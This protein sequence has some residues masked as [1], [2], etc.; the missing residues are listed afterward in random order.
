MAGSYP[1]R[2]LIHR[3]TIQRTTGSNIDTRGLDS[4]IWT[5]ATTNIPCRLVFLSETENRDGRNT[6]IE[7]WTGYFTGTVD[8]KASDRLYWNSE[9]KYFEITSLRKSHNR[10][11]RLFSVTAD[12][13]YFE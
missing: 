1:E 13:T 4:D 5:D 9:N 8:L 11:G 2:L 7:N 10:V 12:L 3:V 6:V